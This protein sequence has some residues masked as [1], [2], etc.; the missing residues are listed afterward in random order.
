M[1]GKN[2]PLF[3]R[4]VALFTLTLL[5]SIADFSAADKAA[6]APARAAEPLECIQQPMFWIVGQQTIEE[7]NQ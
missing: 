6:A 4:T 1:T 7:S 2:F 5:V 3:G